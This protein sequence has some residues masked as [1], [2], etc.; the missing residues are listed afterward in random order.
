MIAQMTADPGRRACCTNARG[1]TLGPVNVALRRQHVTL[2]SAPVAV[3]YPRGEA[4]S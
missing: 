1:R 3:P 4:V 2:M